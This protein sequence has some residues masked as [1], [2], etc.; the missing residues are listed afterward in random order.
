MLDVSHNLK[1]NN[2]QLKKKKKL[3]DILYDKDLDT[4]IQRFI[5]GFSSLSAL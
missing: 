4:F 3:F 2:K 5:D 1:S